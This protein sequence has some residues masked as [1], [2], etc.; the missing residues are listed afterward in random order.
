MKKNRFFWVMILG[1]LLITLSACGGGGGAGSSS[2]T[3]GPTL[4]IN[5][6]A[7]NPPAVLAGEQ[8]IVKF[9]AY[10]SGSY[11]ELQKYDGANYIT[12]GEMND[13]GQN[14]DQTAGDKIYTTQ[15]TANESVAANITYRI[16]ATSNGQ[17]QTREISIPVVHI[18]VLATNSELNQTTDALF[19]ESLETKELVTSL[20]KNIANTPSGAIE[21][22][23]DNFLNMFRN[24]EAVTNQ[25][26]G[27]NLFGLYKEAKTISQLMDIFQENPFDPSVGSIKQ[28]V[29][30]SGCLDELDW[31]TES[32]FTR[33]KRR[34]CARDY[35]FNGTIN[36]DGEGVQFL[37]NAQKVIA[38]EILSEPTSLTGDGLS[39]LFGLN[40]MGKLVLKEVL[41]QGVGIIVDWFLDN[42]GEQNILIG[43]VQDAEEFSVP[44]GTHNVLYTFG[45]DKAKALV[46][47]INVTSQQT[48]TVEFSP[49]TITESDITPPSTPTSL[50]ATAVSSLQINLA[51]TASTDNIGVT[52]YNI[53]RGGTILKAATTT[54]I[55]DT[56][57]SPS[58][59]YC[60]SVSAYDAA[61]NE[62]AQSNQACATTPASSQEDVIVLASNLLL[63][64]L[65]CLDGTYVYWTDA[66]T[67]GAVKKVSLNGGTPLTLT[68][69]LPHGGGTGIT[70][71]G[72]S[73]YWA[74]TSGSGNGNIYK[75]PIEGGAI[76]TLAF[77][78][79]P[80]D[81]AVDVNSVYW[82]EKN[83]GSSGSN[84]IRKVPINGGTVIPLTTDGTLHG[85][86]ATDENYIYLR[87][88]DANSAIWKISKVNKNG[89]S[90]IDLAA[91]VEN[92]PTGIAVDANYVYWSAVVGL[93]PGSITGSIKRV[94][95]N[96][97]MV[98]TIASGLRDPERIVIDNNYIYFTEYAM[99]QP[100]AGTIKKV[101]K[102]GG[103]VS[104]V[105]DGLTG[106]V[107]IAIDSNY[108]YWTELGPLNVVT[109]S[110]TNGAVKK[111]SKQ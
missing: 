22:V 75:M 97:G 16:K 14:G 60:Y 108:I 91:I 110:Y 6:P 2:G 9:S 30:D 69:G 40:A 61:G 7:S 3:K 38:K 18:P 96:G 95:I 87:Y 41:G 98:D 23:G 104:T 84:A 53:Y 62:S 20:N 50:I 21:Q 52:G 88:Q 24:F 72:A 89:G 25:F 19:L 45:G 67:G 46:K 59:Q 70:V 111:I 48:T 15:V 10:V 106:P 5:G 55:S 32:D 73:I 44:S 63:P 34:L 81:I 47:N 74:A 105:V 77:A 26:F 57:L 58:A 86:M 71:D 107:G 90:V 101:S 68:S 99:L 43:R 27:F 93:V 100:S 28:G 37:Q 17:E 83:G 4:E 76:T 85:V 51:W 64:S 12:V 102:N 66:G 54:S 78:N 33:M 11:V 49:G 39:S 65:L 94:P 1:F 80:Y 79:Q 35:L 8:T 82:A 36:P 29:I 42:N 109:S 31:T 103:I 56:G 92:T 13:D